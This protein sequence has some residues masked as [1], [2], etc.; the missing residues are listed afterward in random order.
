MRAVLGKVSFLIKFGSCYNKS[1]KNL[2]EN[3]RPISLLPILPNLRDVKKNFDTLFR[4][5][6]SNSLLIS[7][8]SGFRPGNSIVNQLLSFVNS[9]SQAFDC[10]PISD[11]CSVYLDISKD[12]ERVWHE[13]CI[14][15]KL[16]RNA[17]VGN[18]FFPKGHI[19][20]KNTEESQ[21]RLTKFI[22]TFSF[23]FIF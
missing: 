15:H 7:N 2:K 11:A 5:F 14:L 12:V 13:V 16:H 4:A 6:E 22:S 23:H 17:G 21:A 3:Y 10:I 20:S 9:M 18:Y 1:Q 19:T 8:Q